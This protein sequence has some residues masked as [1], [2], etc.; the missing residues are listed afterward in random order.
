MDPGLHRFLG[1][2]KFK[3]PKLKGEFVGVY[4]RTTTGRPDVSDLVLRVVFTKNQKAKGLKPGGTATVLIAL[5]NLGPQP[6]QVGIQD[7]RLVFEFAPGSG[8]APFPVEILKILTIDGIRGFDIELAPNTLAP[9]R[10]PMSIKDAL[11][12]GV[13]FAVPVAAAGNVL[14]VRADL[15]PVDPGEPDPIVL[16]DEDSVQVNGVTITFK[17]KNTHDQN[18]IHIT[19]DDGRPAA[20]QFTEDNRVAPGGSL[21]LKLTDLRLG[22]ELVFIAGRGGTIFGRCSGRVLGPGKAT[23]TWNPMLPTFLRL[24]C[25]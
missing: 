23:I 24:S 3:N 6:F 9:L 13:K 15:P 19:R 18:P 8:G 25:G 22:E 7:L 5:E 10:L 2:V 21:S 16:T 20:Q 12:L 4:D 1:K 11:I 17:L 14:T